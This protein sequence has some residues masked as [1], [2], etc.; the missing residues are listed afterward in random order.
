MKRT[1][2]S[3]LAAS[4]LAVALPA[5]ANAQSW[6]SINQRQANLYERID[7]GVRQ[8]DLTRVEADRLRADFDALARLEADYRASAPGLTPSETRDLDQRFDALSQRIR[9]ERTDNDRPGGGGAPPWMSINERQ[10]NLYQRIED[11]MRR[12]DLTRTEADQL[13]ADFNRLAHIEV[14]YRASA[15]GLTLVETQDLDRRFDALSQRI[16]LERTDNDRRGD[17]R[18]GDH[19][20]DHAWN[21]IQERRAQLD[22][23]IDRALVDH[24]MNWREAR[25]LKRQTAALVR[26]ETQYRASRPGLTRTERADLDRRADTISTRIHDEARSYGEGYGNGYRR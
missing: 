24:R 22:M 2:L 26:L 23:R 15:P 12:G 11:G 1:L 14:D 5:V 7:T 21:N 3:L 13:R 10:A 18:D 4:S 17:N 16:R 19:R 9:F 6:M 25:D 8:G 20:G